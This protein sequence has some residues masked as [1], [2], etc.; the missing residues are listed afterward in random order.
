VLA[1][2]AAPLFA[3]LAWYARTFVLFGSFAA[4]T[5]LGMSFSKITTQQGPPRERAELVARGE[6]SPFAT[7]PPFRAL[8][9]YEDW[10]EPVRPTGVPAL[11]EVRKST[12]AR[13]LNHA[14]YVPIARRY[15]EDALR[16]LRLRPG[17]YARG[18]RTAVR[19]SFHPAAGGEF[20]QENRARLG[21][22]VRLY[23]LLHA[24]GNAPAIV[25]FALLLAC[26]LTRTA[27]ALR[28]PR[29]ASAE[30]ATV[31]VLS[32][33][34]L[35]VFVVGNALDVG[36]NYRFRFVTFPA[37]F[38]LAAA[39]VGLVARRLAAARSAASSST[40]SPSRMVPP[41]STSARR[42]PR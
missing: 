38:A 10:I 29:P 34:V 31:A 23:D 14:A 24:G 37:L 41:T 20:L 4:S 22:L 32:A 28:R 35:W 27:A 8:S 33:T 1:A 3:V 26:G 7:V 2:A 6:L 39:W 5:W 16:V 11:D 13:N 42:P 18:L 12:G 30:E 40:G 21:R 25:L 17:W 36:E 9:V 15:W 19:N